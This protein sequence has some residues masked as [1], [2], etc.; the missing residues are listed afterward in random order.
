[1]SNVIANRKIS[2]E[3]S[4]NEVRNLIVEVRRKT[5]RSTISIVTFY[6]GDIADDKI[7]T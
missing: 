6:R 3:R 7:S 4:D 2:F 1:M 5:S